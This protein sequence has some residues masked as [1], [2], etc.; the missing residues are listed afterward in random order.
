MRLVIRPDAEIDITEGYEWYEHKQQCLGL[1]FMAAV[2]F[3]ITSVLSDPY[4]FPCIFRQLRRAIVNRFPYGVFFIARPDAV[5]VVA[6]MH[7]ARNPRRLKT[8]H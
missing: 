1:E 2:S 4:H 8:R 5:V 7:H 6:A 3:T